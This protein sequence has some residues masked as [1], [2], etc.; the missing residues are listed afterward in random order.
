MPDHIREMAIDAHEEYPDKRLVIHFMQPHTPYIGPKADEVRGRLQDEHGMQFKKMN[1]IHG[2]E[3]S[4]ESE[5]NFSQLRNAA[6][7]GYIA[8][9]TLHELYRENLEIVLDEVKHLLEEINGKSVISSDHGELL[10]DGDGWFMPKA[11]GHPGNVYSPELRF[12]PW[13]EVESNNRRDIVS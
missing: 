9:D 3:S 1:I 12:V 13:L 2:E 8:N 10:G 4:E 5:L 7:K 11:Y 6:E